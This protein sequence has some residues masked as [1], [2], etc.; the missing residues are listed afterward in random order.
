MKFGGVTT[1][2]RMNRY[3]IFK[4]FTVQN[5]WIAAKVADALLIADD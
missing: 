3:C 5:G 2:S 4:D 1:D